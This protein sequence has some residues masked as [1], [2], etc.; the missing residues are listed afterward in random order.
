MGTLQ[1]AAERC[2][3]A[4]PLRVWIPAVAP[5]PTTS[6]VLLSKLTQGDLESAARHPAGCGLY[7]GRLATRRRPADTPV[8][9]NDSPGATGHAKADQL[10]ISR[11]NRSSCHNPNHTAS[12]CTRLSR[13]LQ[14]ERLRLV[15]L[16]VYIQSHASPDM[17]ALR[18]RA[19][20]SVQ[21]CSQVDDILRIVRRPV[22]CSSAPSRG[23]GSSVACLRREH[24]IQPSVQY[25]LYQQPIARNSSQVGACSSSGRCAVP[26]ARLAGAASRRCVVTRAAAEEVPVAPVAQPQTPP[27][28][29]WP[30]D[31]E[32]A[33]DV[34]AFGGSLPEVRAPN[35]SS[36]RFRPH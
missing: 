1:G 9:T 6:Y 26:L 25:L 18:A 12:A 7:V 8:Y 23:S 36:V 10:G 19:A 16:C 33:R 30:V 17:M 32:T 29:T 13:P 14:T 11:T 28:L 5:I 35:H 24:H 3:P 22:R 21:V 2:R 31:T 4:Y 20:G 15:L 27:T 34:F